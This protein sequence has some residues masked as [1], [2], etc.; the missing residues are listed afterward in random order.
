MIIYIYIYYIPLIKIILLYLSETLLLP[1]HLSCST[2]NVASPSARS[3]VWR[4]ATVPTWRRI[5]RTRRSRTEALLWRR[6][7][8][9]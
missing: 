5:A 7:A 6:F 1:S 2:R 9:R 3:P 8:R 4:V